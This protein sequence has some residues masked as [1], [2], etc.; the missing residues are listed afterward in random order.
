MK[1]YCW[2]GVHQN[3]ALMGGYC[4]TLTECE[5]IKANNGPWIEFHYGKTPNDLKSIKS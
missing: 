4:D 1:N 3:G 2:T 5:T